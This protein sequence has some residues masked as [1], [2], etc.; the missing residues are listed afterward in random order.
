MN[1]KQELTLLNKEVEYL[2][3]EYSEKTSLNKENSIAQAI[4]SFKAIFKQNA[5][6]FLLDNPLELR[7]KKNTTTYT[8]KSEFDFKKEPKKP[9]Q[10]SIEIKT[11]DQFTSKISARLFMDKIRLTNL[12]SIDFLLTH[13]KE[14]IR[15][16][17]KY[18][19]E[20]KLLII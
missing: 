3:I 7:V 16:K 18:M 2:E 19:R 9:R 1:K 10:F 13:I 14:W 6:D 11:N 8:I 15:Q 5:Y 17:L 4:L 12:I 20:R